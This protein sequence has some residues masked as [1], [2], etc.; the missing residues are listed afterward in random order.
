MKLDEHFLLPL[1]KINVIYSHCGDKV[2]GGGE[3]GRVKTGRK[4]RARMTSEGVGSQ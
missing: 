1:D 3:G 4:R 2:Q